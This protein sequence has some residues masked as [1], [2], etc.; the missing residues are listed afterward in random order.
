MTLK[1]IS[2]D[3][4][5]PAPPVYNG[6]VE[7]YIQENA[8][9]Q[10]DFQRFM[11]DYARNIA[12]N[13]MEQPR[14]EDVSEAI[15]GDRIDITSGRLDYQYE[16]GGIGFQQNARYDEEPVCVSIQARHSMRIGQGAVARPHIHWIQEQSSVPNWLIA[17]KKTNYGEAVTVESDFSNHTLAIIEEHMFTYSSGAL[18]QISQFPEIDISDL[19]LSGSIDFV[20]F[21]DSGNDSGLFSGSDPVS[22]TAIVK[23]F[24]IHV[25]FDS[26]GSREE[27]VK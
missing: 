24:D 13:V 9:W 21:R 11:E 1:N 6:D 14:W 16:N 2:K 7:A 12:D 15:V 5:M 4:Q 25:L 10:N 27:Y 23:Y 8:R 22:A 19:S 17:Y 3:I 26:V 20:L 18:A